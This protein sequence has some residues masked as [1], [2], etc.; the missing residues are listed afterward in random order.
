MSNKPLLFLSYSR[1]NRKR[2][3]TLKSHLES[4][5]FKVWMDSEYI[6]A[7]RLWR[8]QIIDAL[9]QCVVHVILL[10]KNS[11]NSDNVRRELDIA[12]QKKKPILPISHDLHASELSKEMEYQL[13]GLQQIKYS[14]FMACEKPKEIVMELIRP[15]KTRLMRVRNTTDTPSL[16]HEQDGQ[17]I[18]LVS[19]E[20]SI[21]RGPEVDI[22]LTPWDRDHY[23]SR[24]HAVIKFDGEKWVLKSDDESR[25]PTLVD[26]VQVDPESGQALTD[27]AKVEFANIPFVYHQKE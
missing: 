14:E 20:I 5:G 15:A 22:D 26:S 4:S 8:S 13:V 7:G 6:R 27:G 23:V 21:G 16:E 12:R 18:H 1:K 25:N 9:E 3:N 24:R 17:R 11:I 10:T 2:A 19:K